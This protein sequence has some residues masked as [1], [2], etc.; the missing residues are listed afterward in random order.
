MGLLHNF[1]VDMLR[2]GGLT[3]TRPGRGAK[4]G[5]AEHTD[6]FDKFCLHVF[7]GFADAPRYRTLNTLKA[8]LRPQLGSAAKRERQTLT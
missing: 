4:A 7:E 6:Y 1:L 8:G 5:Y 3:Y 2:G